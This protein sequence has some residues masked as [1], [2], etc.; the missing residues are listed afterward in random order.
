MLTAVYRELVVGEDLLL[1]NTSS[2]HLLG[3]LFRHVLVPTQNHG[4]G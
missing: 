2:L 1:V 4:H 3:D